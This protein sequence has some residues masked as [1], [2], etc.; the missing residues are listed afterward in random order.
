MSAHTRKLFDLRLDLDLL[1][2]ELNLVGALNDTSSQCTD[3]LISNKQDRT[4][5]SPKIM[6][7]MM[8]DTA[9]LTHAGGG[10]DHLRF[11]VK[12]D[13][14]GFVTGDR[15]LQSRKRN[16]IDIRLHQLQC[17]T[18]KTVQ[19]IVLENT[20]CLHGQRG[21]DEYGEIL[22]PFHQSFHLDLSKVE[23]KLLCTP[24]REGRNHNVTAP[25]KGFLQDLSQLTLIIHLLLG[26]QPVSV[27]GLHHYVIRFLRID[28]IADQR[29]I[30]ITNV[31]GKHDLLRLSLFRHPD[32]YAG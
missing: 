15:K 27:G 10:D 3:C 28:G 20:R 8:P 12:V 2:K 21:I 16:G 22:M 18:G 24:D 30:L 6:F 13:G 29:L 5:R 4:F 9:G 31:S 1:T 14:L 25:I 23:Q 11:I 19:T 7:Q 26:M 32:L 17:L